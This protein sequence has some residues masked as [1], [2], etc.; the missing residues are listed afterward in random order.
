MNIGHGAVLT[1]EAMVC[2]AI[3]DTVRV[4]S[5]A[6]INKVLNFIPIPVLTRIFEHNTF[7]GEGCVSDVGEK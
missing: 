2:P 5:A 7:H 4:S 1:S 3:D 6:T